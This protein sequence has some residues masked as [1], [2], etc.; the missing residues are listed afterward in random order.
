MA[1]AIAEVGLRRGRLAAA[2]E[3]KPGCAADAAAPGSGGTYDRGS[4]TGAARIGGVT[5]QIVRDWVLRFNAEAPSGLVDRTAHGKT[6]LLQAE[7]RAALAPRSKRGRSLISTGWCDGASST[8]CSGS[9][10]GSPC[11]SAGRRSAGRCGR[12]AMRSSPLA[13][14]TTR[15]I[16]RPRTSSKKPS[17]RGRGHL[18]AFARR[19]A[20]RAL[21]A[22]R[23]AGRAEE[24]DHSPLG[25]ARHAAS[26]PPTTSARSGPT[27]S[28]RSARRRARAPASSCPTATRHAGASRRVRRSG[29]AQRPRRAHPRPGRLAR[30]V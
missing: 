1:T 5:L 19:H 23:G 10:S 21:V 15:R 2:R 9:G 13:R 16:P 11:R 12:W 4:R 17:G 29:R 28:A 27:S 30:L 14:G 7:H 24:Q 22:G 6:P 26:G 20:R 8:S 18:C 25:E 3:S